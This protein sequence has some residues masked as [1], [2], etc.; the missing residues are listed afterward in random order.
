M[1]HQACIAG[2]RKKGD[3]DGLRNHAAYYDGQTKR[4][5]FKFGHCSS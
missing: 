1:E 3:N 5:D 4:T 2:Q